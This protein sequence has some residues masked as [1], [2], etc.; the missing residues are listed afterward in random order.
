MDAATSSNR[1]VII[2]GAGPTGLA[3]ACQCVRF[4]IDFVLIDR[5]AGIT[6]YSKAIGVQART[7]EIHEQIGLAQELISRG[8]RAERGRLLEGGEVRGTIEI[9]NLGEGLS[10]FPFLLLVEQSTHEQMLYDYLRA[11]DKDVLWQTELTDFIQSDDGVRAHVRATDG[12]EMQTIHAGYL[13]GCDG[14]RSTV[15]HALGR[16]FEG[17]TFERLFYVADTEI[18]WKFS[19]DAVMICFAK[20]NL[21]VFFPMCGENRYRIVGTFPEDTD[22]REGE[23]AYAEI[24]EQIKRETKLDLDITQVNWFSTYNV[25]SRRVDRFSVGRCFLAGDAAHIHTPAGAQGMNTGIQDGYNLAWKLAMVL[26]GFADPGILETYNEERG[27]NAKHLLETTDRIF[28]FGASPDRFLAYFRTHIL[29]HIAGFMLSL[30]VVKKA[31]FPLI[32]QI[33]INYRDASLSAQDRDAGFKVHAGDRMPYFTLT[34]TGESIYDSLRAPKFHYLRFTN[35][36]DASCETT[37]PENV[38][39]GIVGEFDLF[40]DCHVIPLCPAV[41]KAFGTTRPFAALLRPDNYI[42]YISDDTSPAALRAYFDG[43]IRPKTNQ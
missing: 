35:S 20:S 30:D 17:T 12:G 31:V 24:E 42:G 26:R 25:H 19:H 33:G 4:G 40:V 38:G 36:S 9:A 8:A 34:G 7:L 2:V 32:S 1:E 5:A 6:P 21:T 41:E 3:L 13:V 23:V 43:F 14:A 29:P 37:A 39:D 22:K 28:E 15:R 10:P 27:E 11:H 18:D 16:T